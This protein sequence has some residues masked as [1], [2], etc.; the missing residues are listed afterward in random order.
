MKF[1]ISADIEGTSGICSW[2]ETV[3]GSFHYDRQVDIMKEEVLSCVRAISSVYPHAM[4]YIKD[5]HNS[6]M[7]MDIRNFPENCCLVRG[8]SGGP[9]SMMEGLDQSF[10]GVFYIGYHSGAY[11]NLN[12]LAH[13]KNSSKYNRISLNDRVGSEFL[14]NSYTALS[15]GVPILFISGDEN[16][17]R[18]A[19]DFDPSIV[20]NPILKGKGNA[21]ISH[22]P[23]Y[24]YKSIYKNSLKAL[25]SLDK[26]QRLP[27]SFQLSIEFIHHRDAYRASFY[28]GMEVVDEKTL[29]F[30][31]EDF[32]D[33]MNMFIFI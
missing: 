19:R 2:S 3:E 32:K 26:D 31:S 8:W 28:P 33:I 9:L 14:I 10:D 1:F 30:Y 23:I 16:I 7:N 6:G 24:N 27:E 12:P 21:S 25:E 11:S 4:I 29:R 15:L 22:S 17:C 20:T 13:T 18:E 5:A